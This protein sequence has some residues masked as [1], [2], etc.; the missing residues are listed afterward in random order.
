MVVPRFVAKD[1]DSVLG[2]NCRK[3]T[4]KKVL[5]QVKILKAKAFEEFVTRRFGQFGKILGEHLNI[6]VQGCG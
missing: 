5:K 1:T 3:G 2:L 4:A 6:V